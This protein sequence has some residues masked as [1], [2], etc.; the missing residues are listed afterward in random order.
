[1]TLV[2]FTAN[3]NTQTLANAISYAPFGPVTALSYG[4]GLS[5]SQSFDNAYRMT[6]QTIAG[7]LV[8]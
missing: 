8:G 1:M 5:L 6:G 7:V 4:N 2:N 3:G